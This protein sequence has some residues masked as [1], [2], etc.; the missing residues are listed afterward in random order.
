MYSGVNLVKK[1]EIV[2]SLK[3]VKKQYN[4]SGTNFYA[5][6]GVNLEIK[7]GEFLSIM[8]P[9]GSGKST[10]LHMLGCLDNPTSGEVTLDSISTS[11]LKEDE[12]AQLRNSK[13]GFVFQAFNLSPTMDV[14]KNVELPLIV[15]ELDKLERSK[16]VLKYLKI[17]GLLHRQHNSPSQL[18][19]GEKQRVAIAR[20]LVNDPQILLAD[21]PTGNLDSKSGKD[22]MDF[23]SSLWR[24]YGITVIIVTHEP[25]VA[26]YSQRVIHIRDGKVEK[27][28]YQK[29][30]DPN[31]N[32]DIKVKNL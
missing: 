8:G 30:L 12:L 27:D 9:S 19:G 25:V 6:N 29:P 5:L 22:V 15:R 17:V 31:E 11:D 20:A 23:I 7:K 16:K 26:S 32:L 4:T 28:I 1:D 24:T 10:L 21:E 2:L 14:F 18:S 13:I 3:D